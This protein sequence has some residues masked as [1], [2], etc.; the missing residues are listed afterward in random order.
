[1]G[2]FGNVM[3]V[4]IMKVILT[5]IIFSS[6]IF[7][8]RYLGVATKGQY[9]FLITL[10][11]TFGNLLTAGLHLGNLYFSKT[12]SIPQ[13]AFQS[14]IYLGGMGIVLFSVGLPI[15]LYAP[16]LQEY[17]VSIKIIFLSCLFFESAWNIFAYLYVAMDNLYQYAKIPVLRRGTFFLF[18]LMAFAFFTS[19]LQLA[20]VFYLTATVGSLFYMI[21]KLPWRGARKHF[22]WR[23]LGQSLKYGCRSQ[24]LVM[25][26]DFTLRFNVI[27]LGLWANPA[28]NG[29]YSVALN[30]SQGFPVLA[31]TLA[32]V[33]QSAVSLSLE[34]QLSRFQKL[35]RHTAVLLLV[36][37]MTLAFLARPLIQNAYGNDF[38]G[39]T[40]LL[41]MLIPGMVCFALYVLIG[42]FML[43][44]GRPG[45]GFGCSV[46]GLL[47]NIILSLYL[48]PQKGVFG[49]VQSLQA[50]YFV[51]AFLFI[52]SLVL[53]YKVN[54]SSLFILNREDI[55]NMIARFKRYSQLIY[56]RVYR[57]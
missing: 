7:I 33:V 46:A 45:I 43:T 52:L 37:A 32:T 4:G 41:Q 19:S 35:F 2:L 50:G 57:G 55:M 51:S 15:L 5:F 47:V 23:S 24:A 1:M 40:P 6:D 31:V 44:N 54:L 8:S 42:R 20:L 29:L 39:A 17:E 9:F 16:I 12:T 26:D 10:I 14:I 22:R 56:L 28:Q 48:I 11:L 34:D 13:L 53:I 21:Q 25:A 49:A 38:I 30:L 3:T 27:L 36:A 18:V